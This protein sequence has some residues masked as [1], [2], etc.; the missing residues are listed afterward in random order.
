MVFRFRMRLSLCIGAALFAPMSF[1]RA[2][3]S[4]PNYTFTTKALDTNWGYDTIKGINTPPATLWSTY[5]GPDGNPVVNPANLK[6]PVQLP[7]FN[8]NDPTIVAPHNPSQ[9]AI[10]TGVSIA[11]SY[12]LNNTFT[13][14]YATNSPMS[15]RADGAITYALPS[16]TPLSFNLAPTFHHGYNPD[17]TPYYRPFN[18]VTDK[19]NQDVAVQNGIVTSFISKTFATNGNDPVSAQ[20]VGNSVLQI[21][22]VA[23]ATS[24][25]DSQSGNGTGRSIT[26]AQFSFQIHYTYKLV[27]EPSAITLG[28]IGGMISLVVFVRNRRLSTRKTA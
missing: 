19:L 7:Q 11:M 9:T 18:P 15:V 8:A 4:S 21:P 12:T 26:D 1:V 23:F 6:N 10:L 17:N 24:A 3:F 22:V 20:Y 13:Y 2:D 14:N 27:P 28:A 25:F 5:T 16:S